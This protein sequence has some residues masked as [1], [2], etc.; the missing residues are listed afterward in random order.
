LLECA[1]NGNRSRP[2]CAGKSFDL[3]GNMRRQPATCSLN[4]DSQQSHRYLFPMALHTRDQKLF[5]VR[6]LARCWTTTDIAAAFA[7]EWPTTRCEMED[8]RAV[9]PERGCAEP[10]LVAA[11][12]A[13]RAEF[14]ARPAPISQRAWRLA[15]LQ[16]IYAGAADR[17]APGL[18]LQ[19]LAQAAAEDAQDV[20]SGAGAAPIEA[21]TWT[22][23]RPERPDA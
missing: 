8:I 1:T 4:V 22:F 16:H 3:S 20:G 6:H 14:L 23:V 13:V 5:I 7:R 11:F 12:D 15:Q 19:V 17:N 2:A 10:M 9:D 18:M 21:V